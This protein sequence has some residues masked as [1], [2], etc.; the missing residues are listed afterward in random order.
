MKDYGTEKI[1]NVCLMSHGGAGKTTLAEAMLF[2]A[3]LVDRLGKVV[4]GTTTTDYDPEAVRRRI[5]INMAMAPYEWKDVKTNI[6]DT[7]GYFDFVGEV[8][9]G[10]WASDCSLILVCAKNGVAVGTEKSWN[11]AKDQQVPAM[12]FVNKVDEQETDFS[13]IYQQMVDK[14]GKQVIAF[15]IPIVENRKLIGVVDVVNMKAYTYSSGKAQETEIPKSL[16]EKIKQIREAL[17][18]A[19]AESD[20]QLMEKFFQGEE[21]TAEDILKGIKASMLT[22]SINPVFSGSAA[23]NIGVDILMDAISQYAPSPNQMPDILASKVSNGEAVSLKISPDSKF[24]ALVFKTIVDQFVGKVS[25][26]K[27]CSGVLKHDMVVFNSTTEKTEKVSHLFVMRG[28]K[29]I[30]TDMLVAGDIGAVAK[31]QHT[32]TNDTL[33]DTSLQVAIGKIDFPEPIM[34]L[35]VETKTKG[36]EEKIGAG[37]HKLQDEDLTFKVQFD[38]ETHQTLISGIGEQHLDVIVSKLKSKFGVGV[39]LVEPRVPYRETIKKKVKAE[40][41]H[42]KQS[43]GHGQYGHVWIEFEPGEKEQLTFEE[44]IFGGSVPRQYYPAVEKGLLESIH[45]GVLAGYPVVGLKATLVDGS[46]HAVDSS[47][48]AFKIAAHMAYKSGLKQASPTLLEPIMNVEV[49]VPEDYMGDIIG[50]LNKR[51]GRILGMTQ[52]AGNLQQI[53]AEVPQDEMHK[54]ASDLRAM[55]QG[56][57]QFKFKFD[58]YEEAPPHISQKIIEEAN[59]AVGKDEE[60]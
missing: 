3:G 37:L 17:V 45:K 47:E 56:W 4:D 12:F 25:V 2:N 51:R 34:S 54:Y 15:S 55:T 20:E 40:G 57:G 32:N 21:F 46:F 22:K 29:Q 39:T 8:K 53:S 27:V 33:S 18:E 7:P 41:K 35:A 16:D 6:I 42:K 24:S 28:K 43:G 14:F 10:V 50:D 58:R 31:L 26:F 1:R 11:F 60:E 36:D 23:N 44:K 59:K 49:L 30:P 52:E 19:V 38:P 48:M 9:Q 13:K 5:S